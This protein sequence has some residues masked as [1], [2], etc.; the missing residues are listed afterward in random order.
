MTET[1]ALETEFTSIL[2]GKMVQVSY[3]DYKHNPQVEVD[4]VNRLAVDLDTRPG[5]YLILF[6]N[7]GKRIEVN[8]DEFSTHIKL[9]N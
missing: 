9:L 5:D 7:N 1:E 3:T 6:T 8:L 4:T 2:V